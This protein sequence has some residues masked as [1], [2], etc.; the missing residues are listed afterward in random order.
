MNLDGR[1]SFLEGEKFRPEGVNYRL[2]PE[3]TWDLFAVG[4]IVQWVLEQVRPYS[5]SDHS[6][7]EWLEWASM[8]TGEEGRDPFHSCAHSMDALPHVG[9]ISRFGVKT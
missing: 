1:A 8:A 2:M 6:W 9:D 4:K 3:E 5:S 7:N